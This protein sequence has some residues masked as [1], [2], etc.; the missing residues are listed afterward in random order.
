MY[1]HA[2]PEPHYLFLVWKTFG[3]LL[4]LFLTSATPKPVLIESPEVKYER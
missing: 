3:I 2:Q 4:I 1:V